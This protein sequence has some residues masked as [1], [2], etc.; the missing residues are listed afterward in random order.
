MYLEVF[1]AREALV[2]G[3]TV[4][5]LLVGVCADVDQHFIPV[6]HETPRGIC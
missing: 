1:E 5:G 2:T 4:V 6:R 3:G